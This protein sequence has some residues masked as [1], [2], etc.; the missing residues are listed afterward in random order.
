M[1]R[2]ANDLVA[3]G[4]SM[5]IYTGEW[6]GALP[7]LIHV[8]LLPVR[9]I[10][11]HQRHQYLI[12]QMQSALKS[13]EFDLVIGFNRMSQ[14]DVYF[15]ADP[16]FVSR[17]K[18][19]RSW[20]YR[21]TPRYRFFAASEQAVMRADGNCKILLIEPNEKK[22]FQAIYQTPEA[23]FHLLSPNIPKHFLEVSHAQARHEIRHSFGLPAR[24]TLLL[25]VCANFLL[26]GVDRSIAALASLPDHVR[27]DT[28]L[29]VVGD[30]NVSAMKKEAKKYGVEK[31]VIFAGSRA[32]I[33]VLMHAADVMLHPA[34]SELAGLV[35]MEALVSGL[36][37]IVTDLCGYACHVQAANAGVVLASPFNQQGFN[38]LLVHML[39]NAPRQAMAESAIR[40]TALLQADQSA[41]EEATYLVDVARKKKAKK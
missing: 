8:K 36:P 16:C 3:L 7:E 31:Q 35:I 5:T 9:G 23:R 40:Y 18:N 22:Q 34:R 14:L 17:A 29:L 4:Q 21:F 15:A 20:W 32:D 37:Q 10:L 39:L 11:N 28:W 25:S 41:T 19:E 12:N 27:E 13:E 38:K 1:L 24:A 26:K 2:I 33:P 30:G 6:H